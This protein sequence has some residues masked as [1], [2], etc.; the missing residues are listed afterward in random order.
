[1]WEKDYENMTNEELV[2][3]ARRIEKIQKA[4][5]DK[6]KQQALEEMKKNIDDYYRKGIEFY[7]PDGYGSGYD[8]LANRIY[9]KT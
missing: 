8:I 3:H 4:R 1:M 7:I 6:I 2:E 9:V 5:K